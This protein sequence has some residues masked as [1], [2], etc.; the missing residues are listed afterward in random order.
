MPPFPRL[1]EPGRR[2]L[3]WADSPLHRK[4]PVA[5]LVPRTSGG[6]EEEYPAYKNFKT[7]NWCLLNRAH[8]ELAGEHGDDWLLKYKDEWYLGTLLNTFN[9]Q[10]ETTCSWQGPTYAN[11]TDALWAHP[12]TYRAASSDLLRRMREGSVFAD[13]RCDWQAAMS[14]AADQ[15]RFVG[16]EPIDELQQPPR[17][18]PCTAVAHCL[19]ASSRQKP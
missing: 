10:N 6:W 11:W 2:R 12:T 19:G 15:G 9:L 17:S 13:V 18:T 16:A 14:Q 8:A 4:R 3:R 7:A 5:T 1:A